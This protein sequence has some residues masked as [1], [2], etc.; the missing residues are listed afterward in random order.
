M[1]KASRAKGTQLTAGI[2]V[3]TIG[4]V[5]LV[6]RIA[7]VA[8][9]PAWLIGLGLA[10]ALVAIV[11]R[12]YGALVAGMI[13]LGVGAGMAL[14]DGGAFGWPHRAWRLV[15]LGVGFAGIWA[16]AA[17]LKLNRHLWPL[18]VGGVLV[19]LGAAPFVRRLTFVPPGV[20]IALR[21]WWPVAL[22]AGGL[23]LVL[24]ALRS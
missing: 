7:P 2:V 13:L 5:L 4:L 18:A 23:L 17:I 3:L 24:K 8:A 6:T 20:E 14:G 9:A 16:V 15:A 21:T 19:A 22:V 1:S 10:G 12:S 11:Q